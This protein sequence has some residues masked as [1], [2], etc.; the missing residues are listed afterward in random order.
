VRLPAASY[1]APKV[2]HASAFEGS[3]AVARFATSTA[4]AVDPRSSKRCACWVRFEPLWVSSAAGA[5]STNTW[6]GASPLGVVAAG[7]TACMTVDATTGVDGVET[8]V[9]TR[10]VLVF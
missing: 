5:G 4:R 3:A 7:T 10:G 9:E 8:D 1:A 2:S 6:G